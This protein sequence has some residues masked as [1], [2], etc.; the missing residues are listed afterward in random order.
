M[1]GPEEFWEIAKWLRSRFS[2]RHFEKVAL[3]A[4]GNRLVVVTSM[5]GKHT[6]AFFGF[7]CDEPVVPAET[8]APVSHG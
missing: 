3:I 6:A 2:D 7:V 4:R 8:G 1:R 5:S